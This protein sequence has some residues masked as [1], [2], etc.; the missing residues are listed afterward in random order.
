MHICVIQSQPSTSKIPCHMCYS[1]DQVKNRKPKL[2]MSSSS[3]IRQSVGEERAP[4]SREKPG[5]AGREERRRRGARRHR[6]HRV[7]AGLVAVPAGRSATA[8]LRSSPARS[9]H[10]LGGEERHR[11]REETRATTTEPDLA[12]QPPGRPGVGAEAPPV[13]IVT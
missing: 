13:S 10:G 11:L 3:E 7:V 2:G 8:N 1:R 12:V 9:L 6:H 4:T 5:E